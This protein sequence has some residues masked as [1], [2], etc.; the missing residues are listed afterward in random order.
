MGIFCRGVTPVVSHLA[1]QANASPV[2]CCP[3]RRQRAVPGSRRIGTDAGYTPIPAPRINWLA[4]STY[5]RSLGWNV[6]GMSSR[7]TPLD[8]SKSLHIR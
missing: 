7:F 5:P 1:G 2:R 6:S 4:I 3:I 8:H